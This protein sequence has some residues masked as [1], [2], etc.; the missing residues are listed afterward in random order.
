MRLLLLIALTISITSPCVAQVPQG[1]HGQEFSLPVRVIESQDAKA[2]QDERDKKTDQH[3]AEDLVA[4]Q[5]AADA[6]EGQLMIARWQLGL[7]IFGVLGLLGTILL[8]MKSNKAATEAAKASTAAADAAIKANDIASKSTE[9]QLRAWIGHPAPSYHLSINDGRNGFLF[10]I[11]WKNTGSTPAK[12]TQIIAGSPDDASFYRGGEPVFNGDV[13]AAIAPSQPFGSQWL[14]FS[15]EEVFA[16]QEAPAAVRSTV[17]YETVFDDKERIS[18]AIFTFR[19]IGSLT[20]EELRNLN[21]DGMKDDTLPG[22]FSIT[23]TS[24]MA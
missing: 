10:R 1:E 11:S 5:K 15:P 12:R 19:Y 20:T 6:A 23:Q 8:S 18:D 17:R 24:D 14:P 21:P 7:S 2:H 13:Y 16:M 9:I 4:Q 3:D 22:M